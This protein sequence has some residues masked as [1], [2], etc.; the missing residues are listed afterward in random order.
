VKP[1]DFRNATWEQVQEQVIGL[2]LSVYNALAIA[3]PC[4]TRELARRSGIDLLTVR[5]RVTELYQLGLVELANAEPGGGEGIYQ[6]V[7]V[8]VAQARFEQRRQATLNPQMS[9]L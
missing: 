2:R 3:G 5:P 6:A 8:A 7:P 4:T 9:L 1:I